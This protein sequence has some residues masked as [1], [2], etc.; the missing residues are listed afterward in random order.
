MLDI[1]LGCFDQVGYQ[2]VT[3]G[4]LHIDLGKCVLKPVTPGDQPVVY[5]NG[6]KNNANQNDEDS[7]AHFVSP[8]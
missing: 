2:V 4:Q 1:A 3:A 8:G 6:E 7:P 5:R